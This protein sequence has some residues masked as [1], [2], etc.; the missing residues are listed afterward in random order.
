MRLIHVSSAALAFTFVAAFVAPAFAETKMFEIVGGYS[1]RHVKDACDKAG[2]KFAE[3][4]GGYQCEVPGGNSV[5]CTDNGSCNAVVQIVVQP[6]RN[7]SLDDYL[8]N[9]LT[10]QH[11]TTVKPQGT[12]QMQGTT[13]N[14]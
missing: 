4:K 14:K 13:Q 9:G 8:N 2:G 1:K 12:L 7:W 5:Y 10:L 11:Q 6:Q 3:N